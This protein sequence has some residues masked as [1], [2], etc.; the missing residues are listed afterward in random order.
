VLKPVREGTMSITDKLR[1][2]KEKL[3]HKLEGQKEKTET[4]AH[5]HGEKAE[6]LAQK[7]K[8]AVRT[9]A[10]HETSEGKRIG[11]DIREKAEG[12]PGEPK[13]PFNKR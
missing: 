12:K 4:S 13:E 3:K 10:Q 7:A 5:E 1:E 8:D 6:S 2:T 9:E 11:K